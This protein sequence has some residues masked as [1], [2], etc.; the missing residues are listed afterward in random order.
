MV[1]ALA[2]TLG[3]GLAI[4]PNA[5][6]E[7]VWL[8]ASADNSIYADDGNLSNGQGANIFAGMNAGGLPRRAL[9]RFSPNDSIPA[10]SLIQSVMLELTLTRTIAG[11][12]PVAL[13]RVRESWGE[14]ASVPVGQ[15]GGGGSAAP[16]D[17]TWTWR[18]YGISHWATQG[19][20]FD[21]APS[22][23]TPVG[24]V[25]TWTWSGTSLLVSDVQFWL[26]TPSDNFGWILIGNEGSPATAKR[27]GSRHT[28]PTTARPRLRVEY[29]AASAAPGA[30]LESADLRAAPNPFTA[31]TRVMF[32]L[33]EAGPVTAR[34]HDIAGRLVLDLGVTS[35]EAGPRQ[36]RWDG[37]VASGEP[38]VPGVYFVR[39]ETPAT[40][41]TVR[42]VRRP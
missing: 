24:G 13:H 9:L 35:F 10:G 3:M 12:E 36:L 33:S 5:L 19:G 26:D 6:A 8:P 34:V 14:G 40:G 28:F 7:V 22:A 17:A 38:A 1:R 30:T 16:G 27:F 25:G 31:T 32:T 4:A 18:F 20:S 29:L 2:L 42:V 41:R 23:S 15:G 39:V 21:T 37:L 11:P